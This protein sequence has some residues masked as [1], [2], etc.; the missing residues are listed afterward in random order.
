VLPTIVA[1]APPNSAIPPGAN[2]VRL[3]ETALFDI[4]RRLSLLIRNVL[5]LPERLRT[6]LLRTMLSAV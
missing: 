2:S 5:L 4:L 3:S 6:S 1:L